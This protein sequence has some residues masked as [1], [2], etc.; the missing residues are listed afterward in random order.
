MSISPIYAANENFKS[1][2]YHS[3]LFRLSLLP[4]SVSTMKPLV[5]CTTPSPSPSSTTPQKNATTG[6][7]PHAG[8]GDLAAENPSECNSYRGD[9]DT[10][11][12]SPSSSSSASL[13]SRRVVRSRVRS[14]VRPRVLWAPRASG[15]GSSHDDLALPLGM[16]F[17]A[18]LS[19]VL[20]LGSLY[21]LLGFFFYL[22][23]EFMIDY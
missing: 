18:V 13:S 15:G 5:R 6:T 7:V 16:S 10:F 21:E 1:L 19:Q 4:F 22:Q 9:K 14:R 23:K 17:A 11:V 3:L 20:I 12:A 8:N 2:P